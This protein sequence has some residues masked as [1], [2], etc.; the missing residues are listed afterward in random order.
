M[1]KQKN[2]TTQ[3][4]WLFIIFPSM[5]NNNKKNGRSNENQNEMVKSKKKKKGKKNYDDDD[6]GKKFQSIIDIK[7][8][9]IIQWKNG[10]MIEL[11]NKKKTNKQ[12]T[13]IT[14]FNNMTNSF[15]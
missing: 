9:N 5:N 8:H 4:N 15:I 10:Q 6:N 2:T 7:I 13:T 11:L 1:R 3:A 14:K 12:L